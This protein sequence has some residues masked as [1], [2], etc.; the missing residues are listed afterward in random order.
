M[1][2]AFV[3]AYGGERTRVKITFAN[4]FNSAAVAVA[5]TMTGNT[6]AL[7][8]GSGLL[9]V[10]DGT[11]EADERRQRPGMLM[12]PFDVRGQKCWICSS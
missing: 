9:L 8:D 7:A 2:G 12:V 3:A 5:R 1:D 6:A 4:G 10:K 11:P